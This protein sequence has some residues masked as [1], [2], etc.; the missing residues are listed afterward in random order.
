MSATI[1]APQLNSL[2]TTAQFAIEL[3]LAALPMEA[4]LYKFNVKFL[5]K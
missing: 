3:L 5:H 4:H 2:L 1:G